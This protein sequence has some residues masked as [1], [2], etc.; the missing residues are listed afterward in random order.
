MNTA[1]RNR[2]DFFRALWLA[3]LGWLVFVLARRSCVGNGA[4]RACPGYSG[5]ALPWKEARP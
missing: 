5:C 2:R 3:A 1:P 4:C